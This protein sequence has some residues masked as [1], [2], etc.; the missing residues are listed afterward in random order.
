MIKNKFRLSKC[1]DGFLLE[2]YVQGSQFLFDIIPGSWYV[3]H[4]GEF[5]GRQWGAE[6]FE[7]EKEALNAL[8][9]YLGYPNSV[10]Y[11]EL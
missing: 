6:C 5:H 11:K 1:T 3:Y 7:T 10:I 2:Q 9:K 4:R 8:E